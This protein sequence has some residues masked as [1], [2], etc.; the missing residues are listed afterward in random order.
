VVLAAA[1]LSVVVFI[2]GTVATRAPYWGEAEVLFEASRIHRGLPLYTDPLGAGALE[3]GLPPSRFYVTYPPIL[4][5]ALSFVPNPMVVGRALASLAWLGS[6][7]WIAFGSKK[8]LR[9]N[10]IAAAAFV[11]GI[12]VLANFASTARP[13]SFACAC[14]AFGLN[15]AVRNKKLDPLAVVLLVLASWL[16]PTL[17]GL[18]AGALL[19]DAVSRKRPHMIGLA[20]AVAGAIGLLLYL[21]SHGQLFDHVIRSN[22]QPFSLAT[23][24]ERVTHHLPF[25]APLFLVAMLHCHHSKNTIGLGAIV[26][27]F[28]WVLFA[29][30]KTGS[31]ANYWM[32]PCIAAV[33]GLA[34][35]DGP[36]RFGNATSLRAPVV[37]LAVVLYA[38]VAAIRGSFEQMSRYRSEAV[39]LEKAQSLCKVAP[40]DVIA[41]DEQGFEL[42]MNGRILTT[43]YQFGWLVRQ[44][45]FPAATYIEGLEAPQVKCFLAHRGNEIP[46]PEIRAAITTTF[47]SEALTEGSMTLWTKTKK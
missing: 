32:E 25:F 19:A 4:S 11:A 31:S 10:A 39:F 30:A 6:L 38:D 2:L 20:V 27:A 43:A 21:P 46:A 14:A 13:D 8:E 3:Y 17:L 42:A 16:K 9:A 28:L 18:P 37:T 35:A 26:F 15:R 7:A 12:W 29:I 41:S 47:P 34:H 40:E 23:W 5:Y 33:V 44:G 1:V 36:L 45:K 22:A 24:I